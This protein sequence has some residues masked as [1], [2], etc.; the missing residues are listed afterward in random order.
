VFD[1]TRILFVT[2][3][4]PAGYPHQLYAEQPEDVNQVGNKEASIFGNTIESLDGPIAALLYAIVSPCC[5]SR[6]DPDEPAISSA[7]GA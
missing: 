3:K 4:E 7:I 1:A 6:G 5:A 2:R